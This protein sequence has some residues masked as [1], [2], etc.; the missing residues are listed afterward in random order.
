MFLGQWLLIHQD[1]KGKVYSLR[2]KTEPQTWRHLN[3]Q[4]QHYHTEKAE[5]QWTFTDADAASQS[6]ST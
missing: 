4:R 5:F 2:R 6:P 1:K 3:S